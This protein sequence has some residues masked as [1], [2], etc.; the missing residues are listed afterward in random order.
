[1]MNLQSKKIIQATIIGSNQ[2]QVNTAPR[3]IASN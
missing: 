2:V 1:V 3:I